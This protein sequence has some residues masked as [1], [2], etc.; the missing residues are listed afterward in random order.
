MKKNTLLYLEKNLVKKAKKNH[1]NI[2]NIAENALKDALEEY[3]DK[4]D[5]S[6]IFENA[7][8]RFLPYRINKITFKDDPFF[9]DNSYI[10]K[11][12]NLIVGNNASG[13]TELF[14]ILSSIPRK[15]VTLEISSKNKKT[16]N[17]YHE[18]LLIDDALSRLTKENQE[19][20]LK[21]IK[22]ECKDLQLIVTSLRPI[23]GFE[24]IIKLESQSK[25]IFSLGEKRES[26]Q[27][28][29][30]SLHRYL[31]EL[32]N[33]KEKLDVKEKI[34]MIEHELDNINNEIAKFKE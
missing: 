7:S 3:R 27:C 21:W 13:K 15:N 20:F 33:K 24:N 10:F 31:A 11:Q 23:K 25:N 6:Y 29:L 18:C 17:N 26:L 16:T 4:N 12:T 9:K 30:E 2:S 14:H 22:K 1:L 32:K 5:P 8:T 28:E 19:K 34:S